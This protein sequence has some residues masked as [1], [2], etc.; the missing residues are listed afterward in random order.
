MTSRVLLLCLLLPAS[1]CI[2]TPASETS[3]SAKVRAVRPIPCRDQATIDDLEDGDTQTLKVEGRGG[4]WYSMVDQYGSTL[5]PQQFKPDAPGHEGSKKGR[6]VL[7]MSAPLVAS[8][9]CCG[10]GGDD[11]E[12]RP[13]P[14]YCAAIKP[15]SDTPDPGS[16]PV[17]CSVLDGLELYILDDFEPGSASS[18]WYIDN[19]GKLLS[20]DVKIVSGVGS[21][22][23]LWSNPEGAKIY[24]KS[25]TAYVYANGVYT[26]VD[27]IGEWVTLRFPVDDPD[28]ADE[29]NGVFDPSQILELGVQFDTSGTSKSATEGV[30]LVDNVR[31]ADALSAP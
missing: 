12:P 24:A 31:Y 14:N 2:T 18:G 15:L 5:T 20:A 10:C 27:T 26:N 22:S 25:G 16:G 28:F 23:D 9:L 1:G 4:Y 6:L 11:S 7:F 21:E 19:G 30:V 8:M 13:A 3:W 17:D 29:A